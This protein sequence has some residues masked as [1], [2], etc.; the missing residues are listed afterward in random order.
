MFTRCFIALTVFALWFASCVQKKEDKNICQQIAVIDK[1]IKEQQQDTASILMLYRAKAKLMEQQADSIKPYV[2]FN[3]AMY[4]SGLNWKKPVLQNEAYD[5]IIRHA[6]Q[7]EKDSALAP[8]L[9][10][11]LF[12]RAK[13]YFGYGYN[14]T[15]VNHFEKFLAVSQRT[16]L[17]NLPREYTAYAWLG[18]LYNILGDTRN[19]ISCYRKAAKISK[20]LNNNDNYASSISNIAIA[21]NE[22]GQYGETIALVNT[23]INLDA[24]VPERIA[25]LAAYQ[26]TAQL[27]QGFAMEAGLNAKRACNIIDTFSVTNDDDMWD[28]RRD[29]YMEAARTRLG[30]K[31]FVTA[32]AFFHKALGFAKAKKKK[33]TFSREMGKCYVALGKLLLEK[34]TD[35][36]LAYFQQALHC[37]APVDSLDIFALPG[38]EQLYTENTF[39]EA[40]DGKALALE[41]KFGTHPDPRLLTTAVTAY[42]L[43]FDVEARLLQQFNYDDSRLLVLNNSRQRSESALGLCWRLKQLKVPGNW[44]EKAFYF[45][46]NNKAAVLLASIKRNIASNSLL[47]EDSNYTRI[48]LMQQ[49][50]AYLEKEIAANPLPQLREKKEALQNRLLQERKFLAAGNPAYRAALDKTGIV[51]IESIR[52]E[53]LDDHTQLTEFF[54][55][56]TAVYKMYFSKKSP[57]DF[58]KINADVG[59]KVRRFQHFFIDRNQVS[60]DPAAFQQSAYETCAELGFAAGPGDNNNRLLIIPDGPLSVLPFEA[61]VT[62]TS[63]SNNLAQLQYLLKQQEISYGYSAATLFT[64][65]NQRV[66]GHHNITGFAPVFK[67][68]ERGKPALLSSKKE[69]EAVEKEY[70]GGDYY[71]GAAANM[72][73]FR[74]MAGQADILHIA[75]HAYAD[76]SGNKVPGIELYDSTLSFHEVYALQL[77]AGLVV[78]SACETGIGRIEKSEG[79]MSLARGFYYAGAKNIITSLWNAD[80]AGTAQLFKI[81]YAGIRNNKFS[82]ALR[83]AKLQYISNSS[84]AGA[85]PY[86]WAGFIKIGYEQNGKKD[87]SKW[88]AGAVS[89]LVLF[90]LFL[91]VQKRRTAYRSVRRI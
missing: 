90:A 32:G 68:R 69:L 37:I 56:D 4:D 8:H 40:L 26:A 18:I 57:V 47:Q 48:K 66:A 16:R 71:F 15:C 79:S 28:K 76:T 20:E 72:S 34:N 59:N 73:R 22:S 63:A 83:D 54:Y 25:L 17:I 55:G 24:V 74:K 91:Y 49:Q 82:T 43:S 65:L 11:A 50:L 2:F 78:L 61:L 52:G 14:D 87:H 38:R 44:P 62:K 31:D 67:N 80:D 60:N 39:I 89:I 53:L 21:L 30:L 51:S 33:D 5:N 75:T 29:I 35:S 64:K 3:I 84:A 36:A 77:N 86:Y 27:Q 70:G 10:D 58:I 41:K 85:S 45:A 13:N 6:A 46:E 1:R 19:S 12:R 7:V 9:L 88:L 81:F 42:E 23:A